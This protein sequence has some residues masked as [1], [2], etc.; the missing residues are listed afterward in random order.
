M[1][2]PNIKNEILKEFK[3]KF[4]VNDNIIALQQSSEIEKW[5][6]SKLQEVERIA[7]GKCSAERWYSMRHNFVMQIFEMKTII[8]NIDE[9]AEAQLKGGDK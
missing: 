1:P 2:N 9:E 7:Y 4:V 3:D 6:A 5:L 8:K